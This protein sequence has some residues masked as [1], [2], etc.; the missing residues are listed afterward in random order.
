MDQQ[1]NV[2]CW[3]SGYI[4][5]FSTRGRVP[6]ES[7]LIYLFVNKWYKAEHIR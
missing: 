2:N 4:L 3:S 5:T 1:L 6:V 7:E